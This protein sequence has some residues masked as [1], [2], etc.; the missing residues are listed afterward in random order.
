MKLVLRKDPV[1]TRA[2]ADLEE[3]T[4]W[5]RWFAKNIV[6][7]RLNHRPPLPVQVSRSV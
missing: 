2:V 1:V 6:L 4:G 3:V 7:W 5:P